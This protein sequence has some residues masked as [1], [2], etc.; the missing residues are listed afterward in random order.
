MAFASAASIMSLQSMA[1]AFKFIY[2]AACTINVDY[3]YS[4]AASRTIWFVCWR[5]VA[6]SL[7][8]YVILLTILLALLTQWV[9][10]L[11]R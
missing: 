11:A 10:W 8:Y 6:T 2:A 9:I 1:I 3:K 7:F 4:Y 5:S